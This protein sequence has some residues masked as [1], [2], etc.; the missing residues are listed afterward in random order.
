MC[1][2]LAFGL[3]ILLCQPAWLLAQAKK[4]EPLDQL[5]RMV[6]PLLVSSVPSLL[7]QRVDNW[8]HQAM[9][10][11]GVKWRGLRPRVTKSLRNHGEWRKMKLTAQNLA[12]TLDLRIYDVKN[13]TPE[14]PTFKVFLT[15]Q[16]GVEYEQ[17]NWANG[18]RLWSG[19]IRARTQLR[20]DM[21][22][23]DT[24]RF[25]TTKGPLP[26]FVFRLRVTSARVQY[27]KLVV[28]H[29]NGIGG[30]GAKLIGKAAVD[31]LR[32]WRPSIER[33]LLEKAGA[34][35]VKTADTREVR[36]GFGSLFKAK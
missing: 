24:L 9:I 7:Y 10:P 14:K 1:H 32:R 6:K 34:A 23:E 11:V 17:Q 36:V 29:I 8:N 2:R 21:D 4:D 25:D 18:A 27:D 5:A 13:I 16:M 35:I 15:F 22:C 20:V 28:E 30:D 12:G 26:D 3:T 19:S 31:T 33:G